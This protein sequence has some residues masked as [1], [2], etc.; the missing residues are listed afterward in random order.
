METKIF[1]TLLEPAFLVNCDKRIIYCNETAALLT[2][3][4]VRKIIR[5]QPI[6]DEL[7][8]F[9][10]PIEGLQNLTNVVEPSPYQEV[11]FTT[12]AGKQGK[13]QLTFQ[14]FEQVDAKV[15]SW[16]V[17]CRDVTLEETLQKKYRA[18]LDQKEV[19]IREIESAREKL[20][21]YS[22]NLEKMV[23]ARTAELSRLNQLM[24]ALLDSLGQG[25]FVFD[26]NGEVL[27]IASKACQAIMGRD[28]RGSPIWKALGLTENQ[29]PGFKKWMLTLFAEMLP[30]EDLAPLGPPRF[31]LSPDKEIQLQY[32]PLRTAEG[33]IEG[34]V[35]VATDITS[36]V[37]AQR[38]AATERAHVSMILQLLRNK[39]QVASF[40]RESQ[41]MLEELAVEMEKT[42]P[43][44]EILFRLLHTLKGGAATFSI[45]NF[46]D[47]CHLAETHLG[48]WKSIGDFEYYRR[49][50]EACLLLPKIFK[51]FL[52][53]NVMVLGNID[54]LDQRWVEFP[55]SKLINFSS[56]A[57]PNT[58][59]SVPLRDLFFQNFLFEPVESYFSNLNE[60]IQN[61]SE[62]LAK[63]VNPLKIDNPD[64]LILPEPY[65]N[66]FGTLI[67]AIR[68]GIDHGIEAPEEREQAG[69]SSAGTLS[70]NFSRR[71]QQ[72]LIS[73]ADDGRGIDPAA[74]R[75]KLNNL[76]TDVAAKSDFEVIQHIFDSSFSIREDITELSGRGVGM[77]AIAQ[78][79]AAL[80]GKAWVESRLGFGTEVF[81]EVPWIEQLPSRSRAKAA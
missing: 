66:L 43:D 20:E 61:I 52:T 1:D 59:S 22:K 81:I 42:K 58:G 38:E 67:H 74:V 73:I 65:S 60:A 46:A 50:R 70:M 6:F 71:G 69:K 37:V 25:F 29:I 53:S 10:V 11:Q 62:R 7:F 54:K 33:Q 77:D 56:A 16:L 75:A 4:S 40:I 57:W 30:F 17:F 27:P 14:A 3:M 28:P 24:G 79:A 49:M 47:T 32:Y 72:L 18:E 68:N 12:D 19:Y 5:S 44:T 45:K 9:P 21:D 36:L 34:I 26:K 48:E 39:R 80:G 41:Q 2:D 63:Q 55:I 64:F 76:G 13:V 35:V 23:A 78:A 31:L 51:S 15:T 8:K